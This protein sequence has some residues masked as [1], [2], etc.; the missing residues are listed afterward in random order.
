[1][2]YINI[3]E[4]VTGEKYRRLM[5][6]CFAHSDSA[7][8]TFDSQFGEKHM[9]VRALLM[10]YMIES[11]NNS[12]CTSAHPEFSWPGTM[13]G[14]LDPLEPDAVFFHENM[15]TYADTYEL[16]DFVKDFILSVDGI[17]NWVPSMGNPNDLA[18]FDKGDD[19]FYI[20]AHEYICGMSDRF[21]DL[22]PLVQELG[23]AH[24]V[25][26]R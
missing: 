7:M 10:P 23:I 21:G 22:L 6:Y 14:Y 4:N 1:M 2:R 8:T 25:F 18:F 11:R 16:S 26:Y 3:D 24:H 20:T 13:Q 17:F 19:W 9:D 15:R 5:E 12:E